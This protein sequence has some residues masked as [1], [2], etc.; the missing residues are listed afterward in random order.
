MRII[1]FKTVVDNINHLKAKR[2]LDIEHYIDKNIIPLIN[3]VIKKYIQNK[4]NDIDLKNGK[5]CI[6]IQLLDIHF[7]YYL[8]IEKDDVIFQKRLEEKLIKKGWSYKNYK[9]DF[10]FPNKIELKLELLEIPKT[11]KP[12]EPFI[13]RIINFLLE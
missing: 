11:D 13:F 7:P 9:L 4:G 6:P 3:V 8:T 5:I 12:K 1:S 10:V 2:N